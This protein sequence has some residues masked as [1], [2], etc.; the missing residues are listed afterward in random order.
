[1]ER[2][3]KLQMALKSQDASLVTWPAHAA[4]T[5]EA[6]LRSGD[7]RGHQDT[8]EN[9]PKY[10]KTPHV[11]PASF[12]DQQ[13]HTS[14]FIQLHSPVH[15]MGGSNRWLIVRVNG[16]WDS[17]SPRHGGPGWF[18]SDFSEFWGVFFF[19]ASMLDFGGSGFDV[20]FF[21]FEFE[22]EDDDALLML[23]KS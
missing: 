10:P 22:V 6:L 16:L 12:E 20:F 4:G 1:M 5:L 17:P 19:G 8:P 14:P 21:K 18:R 2:F 15:P 3:Q 7:E 23:K 11:T 9:Y 13:K